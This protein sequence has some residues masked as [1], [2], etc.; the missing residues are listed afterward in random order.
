[1]VT[2]TFPLPAEFHYLPVVS[3][4]D[5]RSGKSASLVLLNSVRWLL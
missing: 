2:E 1:M 4:S 3:E 5:Q